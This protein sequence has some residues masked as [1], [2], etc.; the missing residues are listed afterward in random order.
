MHYAIKHILSQFRLSVVCHAAGRKSKCVFPV[1][2][3]AFPVVNLQTCGRSITRRL[4]SLSAFCQRLK[5]H[6]VHSLDLW[7]FSKSATLLLM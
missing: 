2:S 3:R 6:L 7:L 4:L 5:T 1:G